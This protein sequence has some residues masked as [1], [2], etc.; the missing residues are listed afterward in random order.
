[1]TR[2][3][4]NP[5]AAPTTPALSDAEQARLQNWFATW[6][7]KGFA[8]VASGSRTKKVKRALAQMEIDGLTDRLLWAT[9]A[10]GKH[11]GRVVPVLVFDRPLTGLDSWYCHV[12][13]VCWTCRD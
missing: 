11:A 7:N 6:E 3:D 1:M 9:I 13:I 5:T 12:G 8:S 10:S 2:T 4:A